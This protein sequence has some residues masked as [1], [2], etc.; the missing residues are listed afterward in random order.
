MEAFVSVCVARMSHNA[1]V[2]DS[3]TAATPAQD[4]RIR[5]TRG[6]LQQ[7]AYWLDGCIPI[8]GTRWKIGLEPIIGL[9][10]VAGDVIGFLL[11]TLIILEGI[12][13]GA[14]ATLIARMIGITLLDA[15]G[16]LVPVFGDL[17]DFAYKANRRNS[18]LLTKHLD[19]LEG[20]PVPKSRLRQLF[21][22][23]LLGGVAVL[24]CWGAYRLYTSF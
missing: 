4:S 14:P 18:Q 23:M 13:L 3:R 1:G 22:L 2:N 16:G 9:V 10:P 8:P 24:L 20:R 21:G 11:S 6:R 7:I 17:F 19:E 5:A 12:K 15:V